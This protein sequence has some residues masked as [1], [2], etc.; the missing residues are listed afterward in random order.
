MLRNISFEIEAGQMVAICGRNGNG[1]S[2]LLLA[3]FRLL[4]LNS[5]DISI[6]NLS[7]STMPR[8]TL[9]SRLNIIP[10]NPVIFPGSVRLNATPSDSTGSSLDSSIITALT[11]VQLWS[12]ISSRG[13]LDA[14]MSNIPLSL[15][16]NSF[17]VSPAP[18]S[19]KEKAQY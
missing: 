5:G 15:G 3:L 12:P 18:S 1:K 7:T 16:Q 4:D 17:A 8:P 11:T 6:D 9:R 19:E 14:D 2:S 13:G 10:Q